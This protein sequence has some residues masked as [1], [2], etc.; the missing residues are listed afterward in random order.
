MKKVLRKSLKILILILYPV[1][2]IATIGFAVGFL[3]KT[4]QLNDINDQYSQ[5]QENLNKNSN[6][7]KIT[8]ENLQQS[9]NELNQEVA[10]L[11][12][13]NL[14]LKAEKEKQVKEGYG[15]ID[16][17]VFPFIVGDKS[18]SQYQLVCAQNI[19]NTNLQYC[20]SVSAIEQKYTLFVPAGSYQVFSR[21]VTTDTKIAAYRAFYSEFIQCVQ[22]KG[23][24]ACDSKL[25]AKVITIKV[26]SGKTVN[27]IDP[28][29]WSGIQ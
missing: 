7:S 21:I 8:I 1:F 23:T 26:D 13:E 9:F 10:S 15:E 19:A 22:E 20:V 16:G 24:G 29:D 17:K 6:E 18:F 5:T 14:S 4:K 28:I 25:S 11:K 3:L 12:A 27:N 2:V